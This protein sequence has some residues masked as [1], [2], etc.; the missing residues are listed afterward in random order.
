[1]AFYNETTSVPSSPVERALG[2]AAHLLDTAAVRHAQ[3]RVY[4]KTLNELSALSNRELADL[5][6]SR[7]ELRHVA[8]QSSQGTYSR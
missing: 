3:R 8:W 2:Y 4:R 7:S 1:M 6:L 5:G